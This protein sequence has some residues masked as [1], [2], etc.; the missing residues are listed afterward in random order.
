MQLM[1]HA[2]NDDF[3]RFFINMFDHRKILKILK[4]RQSKNLRD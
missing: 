2:I 3:I 4:L 1:F